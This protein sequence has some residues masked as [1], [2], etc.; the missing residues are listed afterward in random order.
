MAIVTR[1]VASH[2]VLS[3]MGGK[4]PIS[5]R[6]TFDDTPVPRE[7][8]LAHLELFAPEGIIVVCRGRGPR[9]GLLKPRFLRSGEWVPK[10]NQQAL[11]FIV[12]RVGSM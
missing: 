6:C 3:N 10:M 2:Y 9:G 5:L 4:Y 12:R 1:S 8:A 7:I 11:W